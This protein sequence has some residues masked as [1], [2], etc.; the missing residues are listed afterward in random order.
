MKE[1]QT[2]TSRGHTT[3][4]PTLSVGPV[5]GVREHRR[6]GEGREGE[7]E[8]VGVKLLWGQGGSRR[9]TLNGGGLKHLSA[10][11]KK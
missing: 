10:Q 1:P 7:G 9:Q 8:G 3:R 2:E 11:I 5:G 4:L 6:G